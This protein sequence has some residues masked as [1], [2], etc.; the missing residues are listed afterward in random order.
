MEREMKTVKFLFLSLCLFALLPF[1]AWAGF[2]GCP[3]THPQILYD[4]ADAV[5]LTG[6]VK[7]PIVGRER[8]TE[9]EVMRSWKS[10]VPRSLKIRLK[11]E[12][13]MGLM[14]ILYLVRDEN[15]EFS[16]FSCHGQVSMPWT[17]ELPEGVLYFHTQLRWLEKMSICGC[18]N[19]NAKDRYD[20]ADAIVHADVTRVTQKRDGNFADLSVRAS[21]KAEVPV[22]MRVRTADDG[23]F[24]VSCGFFPV[25]TGKTE[26]GYLLYLR[27][28]E[29]GQYSTDI[30]SGNLD[31][32]RYRYLES[33]RRPG[34]SLLD[35]LYEQKAPKAPIKAD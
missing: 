3:T 35:W 7:G 22:S 2:S 23:V 17:P 14:H 1:E 34:V 6:W 4:T 28:D 9:I 30:C 32:S 18:P 10:E 12:F 33:M 26:R 5:V 8:E 24:A 16:T 20:H 25:Q 21:W 27:R 29:A 11:G 19:R 13:S 31:P 15:G